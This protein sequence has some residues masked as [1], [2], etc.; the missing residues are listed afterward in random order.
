MTETNFKELTFSLLG[1]IADGKSLSESVVWNM[2]AKYKSLQEVKTESDLFSL[3]NDVVN[4][5]EKL[6]FYIR[7]S[8][9]NDTSITNKFFTDVVSTVRQSAATRAKVATVRGYVL[10][11]GANFPIYIQNANT[12]AGAITLNINSTGAKTVYINGTVSSSSNYTLAAGI[13]NCY[14]NGTYYYLSNLL[15]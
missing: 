4:Y 9:H 11:S 14:Y 15:F 1:L 12:Y 8:Y 6:H 7:Q 5:R 3:R 2:F 10:R 13:W